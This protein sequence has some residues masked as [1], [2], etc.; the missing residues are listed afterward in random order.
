MR[1]D[2]QVHQGVVVVGMMIQIVMFAVEILKVE[3]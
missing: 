1:V 3:D 2:L